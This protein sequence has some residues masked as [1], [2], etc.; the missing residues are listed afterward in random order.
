[1]STDI[2]LDISRH[3][4]RGHYQVRVVRSPSG[5]D[6]R[7]EFELDIDALLQSRPQLEASILSSAVGA[8]RVMSTAELPVR[9]V[10][11][12]LFETLFTRSVYGAYRAS[13]GVAQQ[14]G[15]RLRVVLR[16]TAPELAPLPW[17]ALFD[18]E[19][20]AYVCR[21][22]PMVR[23]IPAQFNPRAP[24]QI[25][26]PLE[27]LAMVASPR[28][29]ASL[30]VDRERTNL[31]EALRDLTAAGLVRVT[32]VEPA[33]WRSVHRHLLSGH[34]HVVHFIGHGD[35][36]DSRDEGVLAFVGNDG[37]ADMVEAGRFADLLSEADPTP[38]LVVLNACSSG[39]SGDDDMLSA[40]APALV[41]S[42]IEAVAAMQFAVSDDAAIAFAQ[43][44]YTAVAHSR[45]VD[46]AAR[47]G[48]IAILG[49]AGS[50]EWLT[51]VLYLRGDSTHP[52]V[53]RPSPAPDSGAAESPSPTPEAQAY[54]RAVQELEAQHFARAVA[55]FDELLTRHPRYRDASSLREKARRGQESQ[56]LYAEAK[57]E[58]AGGHYDAAVRLFDVLLN[59]EPEFRDSVALRAEAQ[60]LR[61]ALPPSSP[62]RPA[63]PRDGTT[64]PRTPH[65]AHMRQSTRR[66][67]EASQPDSGPPNSQ[68]DELMPV[69]WWQGGSRAT[70]AMVGAVTMVALIIGAI[71][72]WPEPT[73]PGPSIGTASRL[74]EQTALV[75][76]RDPADRFTRLM[77][78]DVRTG[79]REPWAG[80]ADKLRGGSTSDNVDRF[81]ATPSPDRTRVAYL[82]G[83]HDG[84]PVPYIADSQGREAH[85]LM[86]SPDSPC[87]NT[88]RPAWSPD[89]EQLAVVCVF[90]SA[91]AA[92][93][94]FGLW[95][96][97][98][99]DGAAVHEVVAE[100]TRWN[101]GA[102]TWNAEDH[103]LYTWQ[104][105]SPERGA[106]F[107]S[108]SPLGRPM[109]VRDDNDQP[110]NPQR[111]S[112]ISGARYT[113]ADWAPPGLLMVHRPGGS[114]NKVV[115]VGEDGT[116]E[117][118]ATGRYQHAAWS[119]DHRSII[120]TVD[121]GSR[122]EL[123]TLRYPGGASDDIGNGVRGRF[124]APNWDTR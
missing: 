102:P 2:E 93:Y 90:R 34:W 89:G 58:L 28:G 49:A 47:S 14:Q 8:R 81:S 9:E 10:G 27:V 37:R 86:R 121:R 109:F 67:D 112:G 24:L 103:I 56:A 79:N 40:T 85:P 122:Q 39:E 26:A 15:E 57:T 63:E 95:I 62:P 66:H 22:E 73:R 36:D 18:P 71:A 116:R 44:F 5:G 29:L 92:V 17:E 124:G 96:V 12:H 52:I 88:K 1:M 16:L 82:E 64:A 21:Q 32:W 60:R 7:E 42:G 77:T 120:T 45:G 53:V 72:M 55:M 51:P 68:T 48:R 110:T 70:R 43:G 108:L 104:A 35:Y 117:V 106:R 94:S 101:L 3:G 100:Q 4:Q 107:G 41:H 97:D 61:D 59:A 114:E 19:R 30:D 75:P 65:A 105:P 38:R 98:A 91:D 50:L 80:A 84:L 46:E 20:Q 83:E 113:E 118:V 123:V 25:A 33:T 69:R 119:P 11:Q 115:V 87:E 54:D 99:S 13:L 23:R 78:L 74:G 111:V 76:T 31:E 6:P